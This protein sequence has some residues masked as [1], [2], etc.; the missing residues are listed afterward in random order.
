MS[1]KYGSDFYNNWSFFKVQNSEYLQWLANKSH[2]WSDS[3][4]F[5]HFCILSG[6]EMID[7]VTNYE[8]EIKVIKRLS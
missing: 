6:D 3:F 5:T 2:G 7:I 8:P 4:S 1:Q